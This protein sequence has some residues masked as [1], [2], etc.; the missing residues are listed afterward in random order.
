M[1][2]ISDNTLGKRLMRLQ[3]A[4][5]LIGLWDSASALTVDNQL[6]S[7]RNGK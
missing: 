3:V 6:V 5:L 7:A 2:A 1:I 4:F